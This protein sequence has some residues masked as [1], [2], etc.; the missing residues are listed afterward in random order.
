VLHFATP[1][2]HIATLGHCNTLPH[3]AIATRIASEAIRREHA[4]VCFP[5]ERWTEIAQQKQSAIP[6]Q[7]RPET[8]L[9][10]RPKLPE[11][12][13]VLEKSDKKFFSNNNKNDLKFLKKRLEIPQFQRSQVRQENDLNFLEIQDQKFFKKENIPFRSIMCTKYN[14]KS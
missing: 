4:N 6:E 8:P 10:R 7:K 13:K 2:Q 11:D 14:P 1:L 3:W 5:G 9:K 12:L